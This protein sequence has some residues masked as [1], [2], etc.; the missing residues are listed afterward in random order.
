M[1]PLRGGIWAEVKTVAV[2]RVGDPQ[3]DPEGG[4]TVPCLELSYCSR[5]LPLEQFTA[6]VYPE[7][8]RRGVETAGRVAA[9]NDG[10]EWCRTFIDFYRPD[11]LR[12]LDFPHA[13]QRIGA[14]ARICFGEEAPQA[15]EWTGDQLHE[16]KH[17][18][19]TAVLDAL[20]KL[21]LP[22]AQQE[23]VREHREYLRKRQAQMAYPTFRAAGWPIGSGCVE[24]ANKL[25][26]EAR[27]KGPGMHW[28]PRQVN[29]M[30]AL[31]NGECNGR[32]EEVWRAAAAHRPRRVRS[33][34]LDARSP[35][36]AAVGATSVEEKRGEA[37]AAS[38]GGTAGVK[39]QHAKTTAAH[40]RTRR[41]ELDPGPGSAPKP[42]QSHPWR[43][44]NPSWLS[45]RSRRRAAN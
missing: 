40:A 26:V 44:Y 30:L 29:P 4:S 34:R 23:P 18:G 5:M 27:L 9:V 14:V 13:G 33:R 11:A 39:E 1:V 41:D 19:P 25:V 17:H 35:R 12:I 8:F 22:P 3:P 24:S 15:K 6:A 37:K 10:A 36:G 43:R 38:A 2:G 28:D 45:S 16:L 42:G 20:A 31:R 32:W 7:L 21:S